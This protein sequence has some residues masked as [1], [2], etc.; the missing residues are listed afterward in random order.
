MDHAV[1]DDEWLWK[2][3]SWCVMRANFRDSYTADG[4]VKRGSFTIGRIAASRE[5]RCS[6]S[7]VYRGLKR[8]ESLGSIVLKANS[9][10]T[11]ITVCNYDTYQGDDGQERTADEQ[12]VNSER[13]AGE[14]PVIQPANTRIRREEGK[15]GRS[16]KTP[17]VSLEDSLKTCEQVRVE[18]SPVWHQ[19]LT[20]KHERGDKFTPT[21]L[22]NAVTHVETKIVAHGVQAVAAA[23]Q[24][25]MAAGWQGWDND[26]AFPKP[27]AGVVLPVPNE[28]IP[29][30]VRKV[31][32]FNAGTT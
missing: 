28:P 26:G 8:L 17:P 21:G 32:L 15:K 16:N 3:F 22:R 5:L 30:K 10:F 14:Q 19:W 12:P 29:A 18:I 9:R 25:A 27:R 13:T 2:L 6:D 24:K 7:R 31:D 4:L 11:T 1:F 20:Y 23:M